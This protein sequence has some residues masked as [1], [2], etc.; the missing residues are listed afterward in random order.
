MENLQIDRSFKEFAD[1]LYKSNDVLN[2]AT[3]I[4]N[5]IGSFE[6]DKFQSYKN[7]FEEI[8]KHYLFNSN[9]HH[10]LKVSAL[11]HCLF[12]MKHILIE[13]KLASVG[14]TDLQ[15]LTRN[16]HEYENLINQ[17]HEK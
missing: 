9:E 13:N 16:N 17:Y 11:D 7:V 5:F 4:E 12:N 2:C 14:Y 1:Y 10:N 8:K 6:A 15:S 3:I